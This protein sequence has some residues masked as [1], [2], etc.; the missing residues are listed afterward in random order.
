MLLI[1]W[2]IIGKHIK[3]KGQDNSLYRDLEIAKKRWNI[4]EVISLSTLFRVENMVNYIKATMN[5]IDETNN[6]LHYWD[7]E[8]VKINN[9]R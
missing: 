4:A 1:R 8:W 2:N 9:L 5:K 6:Y 7:K 3:E